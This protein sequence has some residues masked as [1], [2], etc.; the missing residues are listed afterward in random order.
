M[1]S[2]AEPSVPEAVRITGNDPVAFNEPE[3]TPVQVFTLNPFGSPVAL[4]L[5]ALTAGM[6]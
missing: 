4:K 5:F 6:V 1:V 3:I 2:L